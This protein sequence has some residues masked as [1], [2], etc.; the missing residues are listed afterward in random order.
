MN[1]CCFVVLLLVANNVGQVL[2]ANN[3][4]QLLYVVFAPPAKCQ[5]HG[6][7][8]ATSVKFHPILYTLCFPLPWVKT[9]SATTAYQK[10][11]CLFLFS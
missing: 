2:Y 3:V 9:Q 10:H 6:R 7:L 11:G 1:I 8:T 4:G 5:H